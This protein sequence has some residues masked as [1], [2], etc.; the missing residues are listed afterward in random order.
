MLRYDFIY[1]D[2]KPVMLQSGD[3]LAFEVSNYT[4]AFGKTGILA[5]NDAISLGKNI[6]DEWLGGDK[7]TLTCYS[8]DYVSSVN[9]KKE[10]S[11]YVQVHLCAPDMKVLKRLITVTNATPRITVRWKDKYVVEA[12][13]LHPGQ[14]SVD[15]SSSSTASKLG[16]ILSGGAGLLSA[17]MT[18]VP[19]PE[20]VVTTVTR[21]PVRKEK[22]K[23]HTA[24]TPDYT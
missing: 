20:P 10:R 5:Y 21:S 7:F 2:G 18:Q 1:N 9:Q 13:A 3:Q 11:Q 16:S 15:Q 14:L 4:S 19:E 22:P 6:V 24:P 12:Q 23:P 8:V 17:F